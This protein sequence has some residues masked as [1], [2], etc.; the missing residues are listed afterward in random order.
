[1]ISVGINKEESYIIK[2]IAILLMLVHHFFTFPQ[3]IIM[4]G[5]THRIFNLLNSSIHQRNCVFAFLHL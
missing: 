1:M 4:G 2:G 3:W 5:G